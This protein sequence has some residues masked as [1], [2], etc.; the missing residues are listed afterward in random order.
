MRKLLFLL[1]IVLILSSFNT[2]STGMEKKETGIH[3]KA[4]LS[5]KAIAMYDGTYTA[6]YTDGCGQIL[7][8]VTTCTG[9]CTQAEM[10]SHNQAYATSWP[11]TANGCF[12]QQ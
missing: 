7:T 6:G 4:Y 9:T 1:S 10:Q 3:S 12:A 5:A 11:R 8:V 2:I